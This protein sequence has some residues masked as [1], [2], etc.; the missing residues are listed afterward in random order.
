MSKR[1]LIIDALNL[2]YRSYIVDPSISSNGQPIGGLKGFLKSLQ[3]LAR[4]T[5]PDEIVICWD[6]EGGSRRRK[7]QNKNYKEGRKPIRLNRSIRNLSEDEEKENKIWQQL[8]LVEYLNE[9]PIKQLMLP[10]VEADDIIALTTQ[11]AEFK[12]DQKVIVSSDK[13]FFQLCNK[14]T[15]LLRPIQKVVMNQKNI[16]E[17]FGIHPNN[18]AL[19]RA[20]CGD[21]SDNISGIQGAGLATIAKRFPFLSEEES[22]TVTEILEHCENQEKQLLIHERIL[23]NKKKIIDNYKLMQLYSPSMSPQGANEIRE[24]LSNTEKQFNK[25]K[26]IAMM[27]KDGIGEQNWLDLWTCFNKIVWESKA[28]F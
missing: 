3:K 27:F 13:D 28:P 25:T 1:I 10:N 11:F 16:T 14:S 5:R 15:V 2:Y 19:A 12:E 26:V 24:K 6:G 18:F 23:E 4:E 20:I 8:R 7:S 17:K 21:K 9:M 22:H